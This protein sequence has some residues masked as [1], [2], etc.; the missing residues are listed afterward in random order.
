M[1]C[2]CD[3][4]LPFGGGGRS[5]FGT[6]SRALEEKAQRGRKGDQEE[7]R[8]EGGRRSEDDKEAEVAS[9]HFFLAISRI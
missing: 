8:S 7:S 1:C 5:A 2:V 9:L 6:G 4:F 3:F